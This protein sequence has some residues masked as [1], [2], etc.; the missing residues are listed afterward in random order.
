MVE[1]LCFL[2]LPLLAVA[3]ADEVPIMM[4]EA[5]VRAVEVAAPEREV[6]ELLVKETQ[7]EAPT[8]HLAEVELQEVI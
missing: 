4:V 3:V 6:Q 1:A 5:G 8:Q 2:L 7:G